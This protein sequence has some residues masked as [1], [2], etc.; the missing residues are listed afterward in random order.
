MR[1]ARCARH[2][3]APFWG[4][5]DLE[6]GEVS[7][8]LGLFTEWAPRVTAGEGIS[9]LKLADRPVPLAD[10]LLVPPIDPVNRLVG[11]GVR[12]TK[13]VTEDLGL[14]APSPPL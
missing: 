4:V 13:H 2:G 7:P 6:H 5:V 1:L 3:G 12:Y 14:E 10:V 8:I 11:A 9:A